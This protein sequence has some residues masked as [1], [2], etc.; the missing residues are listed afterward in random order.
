MIDPPVITDP[1]PG[2]PEEP[3]TIP[4]AALQGDNATPTSLPPSVV[5]PDSTSERSEEHLVVTVEPTVAPPNGLLWQLPLPEGERIDSGAM[6]V[7]DG[8]IYRLLV[9]S[10]F[11]GVEAVDSASGR[12][13]WEEKHSWSGSDFLVD[14]DLVY[15][16]RG[17]SGEGVSTVVALDADSGQEAWSLDLDGFMMG[18]AVQNGI[19]FVEDNR[20]SLKAIQAVG[21]LNRELGA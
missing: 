16:Q 4:A 9:T 2:P 8:V 3:G 6:A 14:D 11:A 15:F 7:S 20:N 17:P 18:M 1:S 12:V 5:P 13:L 10:G 19:L 21:R